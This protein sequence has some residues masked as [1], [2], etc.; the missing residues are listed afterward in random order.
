MLEAG[1]T[2]SRVRCCHLRGRLD[3][4]PFDRDGVVGSATGPDF[5]LRKGLKPKTMSTD[6]FETIVGPFV[7]MLMDRTYVIVARVKGC[8][9]SVYRFGYGF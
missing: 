6:R 8:V 1:R 5:L 4:R 2:S 9:P 3:V 7:V